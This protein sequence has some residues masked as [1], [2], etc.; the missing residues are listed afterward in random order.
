MGRQGASPGFL[1]VTLSPPLPVSKRLS[2]QTLFE[3]YRFRL[4]F[5]QEAVE[6]FFT[7][8]AHRLVTCHLIPF[9]LANEL[10]ELF[11]RQVTAP[12]LFYRANVPARQRRCVR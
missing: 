4:A 12:T 8:F 7:I 11:R 5:R 10:L 1:L 6:P 2:V 9:P 3:L